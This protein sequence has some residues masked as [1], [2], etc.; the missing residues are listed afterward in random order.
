[1]QT[2]LTDEDA[3]NNLNKNGLGI[4]QKFSW[5]K[6]AQEWFETLQIEYK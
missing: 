5:E 2:L 4:A 6:A 1:M 3:R